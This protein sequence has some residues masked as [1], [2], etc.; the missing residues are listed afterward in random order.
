MSN[1]VVLT[2]R[3][4]RDGGR[5][6]LATNVDPVSFDVAVGAIDR[7]ACASTGALEKLLYAAVNREL[8]GS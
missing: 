2:T 8:G 7:L 3:A 4:A 1:S 6:R 5:T